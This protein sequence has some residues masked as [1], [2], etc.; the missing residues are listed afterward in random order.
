MNDTGKC[1]IR[2]CICLLFLRQPA[3][4]LQHYGLAI[5]QC[6]LCSNAIKALEIE[7][8]LIEGGDAEGGMRASFRPQMFL[9]RMK[10]AK[11][12]N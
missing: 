10:R 4:N 8:L 11:F 12:F 5:L 6:G 9:P 1:N 2:H 3:A 7:L